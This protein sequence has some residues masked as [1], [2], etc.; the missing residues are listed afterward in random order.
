MTLQQLQYVVALDNFRHFVKAA[1]S[2]FV[3]QP[4]LTLQVKKLEE[5]VGITIFDRSAQPVVP[6]PL[7]REFIMQ[8]R[9]ILR[10]VESLKGMINTE[11]EQ[12]DGTYTLG[13]IPTLAPYLLPRFIKKFCDEHPGVNLEVKEM[14]SIRIIETLKSNQLN[15]GIM[16][17]PLDESSIRLRTLSGICL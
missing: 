1:E 12:L 14:Q 6:T 13:I 2:C 11:K 16:A 15:I 8:A 5:E 10:G 9:E 7:G 3:A 17:T 4:T